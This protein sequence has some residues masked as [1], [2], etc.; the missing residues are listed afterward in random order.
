MY[1]YSQKVVS[2]TI[3]HLS[4][5]HLP[6]K[7]VTV[8]QNLSECFFLRFPIYNLWL[9]RFLCAEL[10][11]SIN[12]PRVAHLSLN[13]YIIRSNKIWNIVILLVY[14]DTNRMYKYLI[15][16]RTTVTD[17][18]FSKLCIKSP[19][20]FHCLWP[21]LGLDT[22]N[23]ISYHIKMTVHIYMVKYQWRI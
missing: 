15:L 3:F 6:T 8:S 2:R 5:D 4:Y 14:V 10:R 1:K 21:L 22:P 7:F 17:N 9:W 11:K 16:N 12:L 13:S 19:N 23:E 18:N 20:G